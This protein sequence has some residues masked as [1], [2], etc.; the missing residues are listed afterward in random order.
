M[1]NPIVIGDKVYLRPLERDDAVTV[2]PWV[3]DPEMTR[4]MLVYRPMDLVSE[5]Q[6]I[7]RVNRNETD[8]VFGVARREDDVLIGV[9]GL[10]QI[11]WKNRNAHFGIGIGD[12]SCWNQGLGTQT[13]ALVMQ[14]AF[15]TLNLHRV[16]LHVFEYNPRAVRVYEKLGFQKEGLLRQENF[17]E[18][19]YWDTIVMGLLCED[20]RQLWTV[21]R[22]DV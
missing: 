2:Q 17:R 1:K 14:Y 10:H 7:E 20:W 5:E 6:F 11:H 16:T 13:T 19:R 15:D 8:V 21:K 18:G 9:S 22:S 12:K 3:N 4:Y